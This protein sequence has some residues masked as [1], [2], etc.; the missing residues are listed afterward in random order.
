MLIGRDGSYRDMASMHGN[1]KKV[2]ETPK[3]ITLIG[4]TLA[5]YSLQSA[6]WYLDAPVSNSARLKQL[7]LEIAAAQHWLWQVELVPDP[8]RILAVSPAIIASADSAILDRCPRWLSLAREVVE[9]HLPLATTV[10]FHILSPTKRGFGKPTATSR[11]PRQ[12]KFG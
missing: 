4:Q 11:N 8:D 1:F 6:L 9:E 3:A 12:P 10:E 2:A 7:L 5:R